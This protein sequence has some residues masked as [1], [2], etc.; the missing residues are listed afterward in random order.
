VFGAAELQQQQQAQQEPEQQPEQSKQAEAQH[1][2]THTNHAASG[3]PSAG[4]QLKAAQ[5]NSAAD[6]SSGRL[7]VKTRIAELESLLARA[8]ASAAAAASIPPLPGTSSGGLAPANTS[9]RSS[10]DGEGVVMRK[11]SDGQGSTSG[12][13]KAADGKPGTKFS[14]GRPGR[15][16]G[17][18]AGEEGQAAE[19]TGAAAPGADSQQ[20]QQGVQELQSDLIDQLK[21]RITVRCVA[22]RPQCSLAKY[23][24]ACVKRN[25]WVYHICIFVASP[26]PTEAH[27]KHVKQ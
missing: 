6:E 24:P 12:T 15:T 21:E 26:P 18:S 27:T 7:S 5:G 13:P 9:R 1:Q 19:G 17:G 11:G 14:N 4:A 23:R 20:Q 2:N 16:N 25:G 22:G 8:Q 10:V 3:S